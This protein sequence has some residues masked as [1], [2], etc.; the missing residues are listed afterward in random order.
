MNPVDNPYNP[1]AG[2]PP[3]ELAGRE[4]L[5]EKALATIQRAKA[6][7]APKSMIMLGLR[8]V[9]K[10]VLLNKFE[11]LAE[12]QGCQTALFEA[13]AERSLPEM[14]T[15]QLHRLLLRLNVIKRVGHDVQKAFG[16][17]R[18]FAGVFKVSIGE[19][20]FGL[21]NEV[22]TGDL[23]IDLSD[24]FVAVGEA[25]RARNVAVVLLIDEVQSLSRPDLSALIMALHKIAQRQLPVLMFAAGLPQLAKLAGDTKSYAERLFDY[26]PIGPLDEDAARSA[27]VAPAEIEGVAYHDAALAHILQE[28]ERYPFFLQVWGSHAWEAAAQ[29]PITRKD[30]EEATRRSIA[31]LDQGFFH[32]RFARLT[33]RQ[34]DYARALAEFGPKGAN[35]TAVAERIGLSVKQAAPIRDEVI[36]K[37]MAYAPTRGEVAFTVPKFDDFL[38]R[39]MAEG[40]KRGRSAKA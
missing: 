34:L 1:G 30:A 14:L 32:V 35:S 25:A 37:G 36:K 5:I 11:Q 38:R 2:A 21:S 9:G 3:P 13:D 23:A 16:Q 26:P 28:T 18:A 7:R 24:L 4:P 10:T 31:A 22:A 20:E 12:A 6:G 39:K 40:T 17:L 33:E 19:V 15:P 29:S 8:G 27:L